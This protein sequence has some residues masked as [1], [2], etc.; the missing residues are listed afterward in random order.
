[1]QDTVD[2]KWGIVWALRPLISA[3]MEADLSP[4]T[5]TIPPWKVMR[6]FLLEA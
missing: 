4:I 2:T 3:E 1:M 5:N 6:L